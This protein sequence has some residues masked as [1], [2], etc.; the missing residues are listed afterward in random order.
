MDPR[1]GDAMFMVH[2]LPKAFHNNLSDMCCRI[3]G[4]HFFF[5]YDVSF[6]WKYR[7]YPSA[8]S[9]F[10]MNLLHM[11]SMA[12]FYK[13]RLLSQKKVARKPHVFEPSPNEMLLLKRSM[14]PWWWWFWMD[15]KWWSS[16]NCL[17]AEV[18]GNYLMTY[19]KM[20]ISTLHCRA[21]SFFNTIQSDLSGT[22]QKANL[23]SFHKQ[24]F[25]IWGI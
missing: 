2:F 11:K 7:H 5:F 16:I 14:L 20:S 8:C 9:R 17:S 25:C 23:D 13:V 12:C 21:I 15:A 22:E 4:K 18:M 3:K 1:S 6:L 24:K 10:K 19:V